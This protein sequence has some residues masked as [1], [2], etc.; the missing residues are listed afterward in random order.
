MLAP[1]P[2]PLPPPVLSF[3]ILPES[4]V[5]RGLL[6]LGPL[7]LL[8]FLSV[9]AP[10]SPC[11]PSI[12]PILR[13]PRD[14][15]PGRLAHGQPNVLQLPIRANRSTSPPTALCAPS[16]FSTGQHGG[17]WEAGAAARN[18]RQGVAAAPL[19]R[20][21]T[22]PGSC[23]NRLHWCYVSQCHRGHLKGYWKGQWLAGKWREASEASKAARWPVAFRPSLRATAAAAVGDGNGPGKRSPTC[24]HYHRHQ[25]TEGHG[26]GPLILPAGVVL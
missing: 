7:T 4:S 24:R 8:P 22:A 2:L 14:P 9:H 10:R 17:F 20:M 16:P 23:Q 15:G 18:P 13:Q 1:H 19:C 26:L 3:Q 6:L 12:T 5:S 25:A 21:G 11:V